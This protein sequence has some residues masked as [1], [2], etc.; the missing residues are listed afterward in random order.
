MERQAKIIRNLDANRVFIA[1]DELPCLFDS[2]PPEILESDSHA[3][4]FGVSSLSRQTVGLITGAKACRGFTRE[5]ENAPL[6]AREAFLYFFGRLKD[7]LMGN[8]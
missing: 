4:T 6:P 8:F 2:G 1:A 3:P 5:S 7:Y